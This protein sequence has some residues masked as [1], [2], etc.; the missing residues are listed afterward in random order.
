MDL[1]D[2]FG[3]E[4][5]CTVVCSFWKFALIL[6]ED[7]TESGAT[8]ASFIIFVNYSAPDATAQLLESAFK[9]G[10]IEQTEGNTVKRILGIDYVLAT[11]SDGVNFTPSL[12]NIISKFK[13]KFCPNKTLAKL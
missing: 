13:S 4:N 8:I 2:K 5:R 10:L 6:R 9:D 1:F 12:D 3:I 7:N 11:S